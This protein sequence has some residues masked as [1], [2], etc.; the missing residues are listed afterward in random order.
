MAA[1][2]SAAEYPAPR[3]ADYTIRDFRFHSG[4]VLPELRLH[5]F[6]LGTPQ[7]DSHGMVRNAVLILHG[8]T[9]NGS[10]FF[11]AEFASQ[12][13]TRLRVPGGQKPTGGCLSKTD[14]TS[15]R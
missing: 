10:S 15:S 14:S 1:W 3:A 13:T 9:G 5:Y 2:T 11:R 6:T 4:E 8:T 12:R 7:R